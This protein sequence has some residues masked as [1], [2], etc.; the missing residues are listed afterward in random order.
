L[1]S[2]H[3]AELESLFRSMTPG[4]RKLFSLDD[5]SLGFCKSS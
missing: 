3:P 5:L 2:H 4:R 1:V